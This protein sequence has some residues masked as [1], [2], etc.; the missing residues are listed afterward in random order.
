MVVFA[1]AVKWGSSPA[2]APFQCWCHARQ[3]TSPPCHAETLHTIPLCCCTAHVLATLQGGVLSLQCCRRMS[4]TSNQQLGYKPPHNNC[5]NGT[6]QR[7][8]QLT[9]ATVAAAA[10]CSLG[11]GRTPWPRTLLLPLHHHHPGPCHHHHR[12]CCCPACQTL[13]V[14]PCHGRAHP[15][16]G[17]PCR[18]RRPCRAPRVRHAPRPAP[19]RRLRA[20]GPPSGSRPAAPR[21][22]P[23]VCPAAAEAAADTQAVRRNAHDSCPHPHKLPNRYA[24]QH[25]QVSSAHTQCAIHT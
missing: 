24:L 8:A 4:Y 7:T 3:R 9:A 14:C 12:C 19:L 21:L 13:D 20:Q 5:N 2:Q 16:P 15:C 17:R 25:L 18:A 10:A 6:H 23:G 1:P 11:T 22:G